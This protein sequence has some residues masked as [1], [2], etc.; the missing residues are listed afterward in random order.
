MRP[1]DPKKV[2]AI[3][4]ASIKLV[5]DLGF[6]QISI[7]KIA[8]EAKVSPATIYIYFKNKE[9]LFIQIFLELKNKIHTASLEGIKEEMTPEESFKS[10]WSRYMKYNLDHYDY[11]IYCESFEN[12]Q[13]SS[14]IDRATFKLFKFIG[15]L[16]EDGIKKKVIK[17]ISLP[18]MVSF[19]FFP[20]ITLLKLNNSGQI[21][22]D[23]AL[24]QQ[25]MDMAWSVIANRE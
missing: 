6:S 11:L 1:R 18:L 5:I 10:I 22:V 20:I 25:A 12:T 17:K 4:N 15:N 23:D 13:M 9:D 3:I 16:L 7:S 21:V 2:E 24:I 14:K 19:S 8:K